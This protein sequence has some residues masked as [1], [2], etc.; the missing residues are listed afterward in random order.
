MGREVLQWEDVESGKQLRG[1]VLRANQHAE[2]GVDGFGEG[3]GLFVAVDD[4]NQRAVDHLP[5]QDRVEGFG[6]EGEAGES[7]G[8]AGVDATDGILE[9]GVPA[10]VQEKISDERV[11]QGLSR[12]LS[13]RW[14][15]TR[16][17]AFSLAAGSQMNADEHG[18][19]LDPEE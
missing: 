13:T 11:D 17:T 3:L 9:G 5:E 4:E 16:P 14:T 18:K 8:A 15:A 6:G 12:I 10:Q 2:E 7:R 19:P 1:R